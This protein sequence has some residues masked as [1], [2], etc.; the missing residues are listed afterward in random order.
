MAI[1]RWRR[2]EER[3]LLAALNMTERPPLNV[4]AGWESIFGETGRRRLETVELPEYLPK[5]RW[6]AGKSRK[7]KSVRIVDWIPLSVPLNVSSNASH[8]TLV[9]VQIE[10]DTG[11]PDLYFLPLAM[12]FGDAENELQRTA[13][14]A[15]IAR[16]V[17]QTRAGVL[18]D[19]AFDDRTCLLL[20]SL[21]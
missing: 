1:S 12:R 16:V 20:F 17:S 8:S 11:S 2:N 7:V 3:S 10:F 18:Y 15:I 19:G 4:T 13:P 21:I 6:F 9:L 5:Q 14:K